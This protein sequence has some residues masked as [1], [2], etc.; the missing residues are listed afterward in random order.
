MSY[1]IFSAVV[2]AVSIISVF[3]LSGP[4]K[5]SETVSA[6]FKLAASEEY[7]E[8]ILAIK[9]GH[10]DILVRPENGNDKR[11]KVKNNTII[12]RNGKPAAYDDLRARD[13]LRVHYD[14]KRVVI[15]LHATGS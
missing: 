14:S 9:E 4:A 11:F 10:G 13:Q 3:L 1:R 7:F 2:I 15:E 6:G 5:S 8:G 12:T